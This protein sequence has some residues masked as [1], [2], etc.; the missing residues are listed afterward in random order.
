VGARCKEGAWVQ[1]D[2]EFEVF[3]RHLLLLA[4]LSH[5]KDSREHSSFASRHQNRSHLSSRS[6]H[7]S[8]PSFLCTPHRA[9]PSLPFPSLFA[10]SSPPSFPFIVPPF[11]FIV[12][13]FPFYHSPFLRPPLKHTYLT[14]LVLSLHERIHCGLRDLIPAVVSRF[15]VYLTLSRPGPSEPARQL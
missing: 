10:R 2:G 12:P 1:V 9:L 14:F 13:P 4:D 5:R 6:S 3:S 11:P 15:W 7:F 8:Q